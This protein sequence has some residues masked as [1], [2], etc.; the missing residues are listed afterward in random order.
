MATVGS[1]TAESNISSRAGKSGVEA[2]ELANPGLA[3]RLGKPTGPGLAPR[4][5]EVSRAQLSR[6]VGGWAPGE[7]VLAPR[8]RRIGPRGL[9]GRRIGRREPL[10]AH[11]EPR[12]APDTGG[13][14]GWKE[15]AV[16]RGS[17]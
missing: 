5:G 7:G 4:L 9:V 12:R 13:L 8:F 1:G 15:E 14:E 3:P 10:S 6:W 2:L 11:R 17:E 16:G